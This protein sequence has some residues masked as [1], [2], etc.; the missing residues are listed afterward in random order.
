[1]SI[2]RNHYRRHIPFCPSRYSPVDQY[3]F[4]E[5]DTTERLCNNGVSHPIYACNGDISRTLPLD[6]YPKVNEIHPQIRQSDQPHF[7]IRDPF[8][9]RIIEQDQLDR[10]AGR[11]EGFY[12]GGGEYDPY[13]RREEILSYRW[14][15]APDLDSPHMECGRPGDQDLD[16][17]YME[18]GRPGDP[19]CPSGQ[20]CF[21]N[22]RTHRGKCM[23]RPPM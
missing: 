23:A 8:H 11:I 18:C 14:A 6:M 3:M 16:S 7:M 1:M 19:V 15:G 12:M 20:V 5:V 2:E 17:R 21:I 10:A 22:Q 9:A 13:R 4:P